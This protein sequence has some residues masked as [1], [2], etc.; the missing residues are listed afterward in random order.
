MPTRRMHA[1]N[2]RP[3]ATLEKTREFPLRAHVAR[4]TCAVVALFATAC[5]DT[6]GEERSGA[7][8][9]TSGGAASSEIARYDALKVSVSDVD[10]CSLISSSDAEG[11]LGGTFTPGKIDRNGRGEPLCVLNDESG[12]GYVNVTVLPDTYFSVE[13]WSGRAQIALNQ[14]GKLDNGPWAAGLSA[15]FN[16]GCAVSF[17]VGRVGVLLFVAQGPTGGGEEAFREGVE[18]LA[19]SAAAKFDNGR[20]TAPPPETETTSAASDEPTAEAPAPAS[21]EGT[22][23]SCELWSFT[24]TEVT[25]VDGSNAVSGLLKNISG[26]ALYAG[27]FALAVDGG[28]SLDGYVGGNVAAGATQSLAFTAGGTVGGTGPLFAIDGLSSLDGGGGGC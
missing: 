25:Y 27:L 16:E 2:S 3:T 13:E 15:C 18:E 28:S 6:G 17:L 20:L 26:R 7:D 21:F 14:Q 22:V 12:G 9:R 1:R 5:A 24:V 19:R 10:S 11:V 8:S 4:V 23:V